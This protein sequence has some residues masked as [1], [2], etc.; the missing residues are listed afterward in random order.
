VQFDHTY[1]GRHMSFYR[2]ATAAVALLSTPVSVGAAQ[3][4]TDSVTAAAAVQRFHE[5]LERGD[6]LAA[7]DLLT[8]D[9][10]VL[11]SGGRETKAEYR[12]HHLPGDIAFARAVP[13]RSGP[14]RVTVQGDVAWVASAG[15]TT[16]DY[17][18]RTIDVATAELM[19]LSRAPAGWRIRAIHWSSRPRSKK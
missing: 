6:S 18:G 9:A 8:Q 12:H 14:L 15:T 16:G 13:S 10:V 2:W 17:R 1:P 11:E 5:A 3:S 19:V 7:L 4:S